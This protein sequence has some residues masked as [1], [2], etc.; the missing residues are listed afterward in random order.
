MKEIT[1][2]SHEPRLFELSRS[3]VHHS[4]AEI[5]RHVGQLSRGSSLNYHAVW[6]FV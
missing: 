2:I 5:G 1:S 4:K 3:A 6:L